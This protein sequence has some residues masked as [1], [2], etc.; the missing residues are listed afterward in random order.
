[1]LADV[2]ANERVDCDGTW[3]A[4]LDSMDTDWLA[5]TNART[6]PSA[7]PVVPTFDGTL[8]AGSACTDTDSDGMPDAWEDLYTNVDK[9]SSDANN[10]SDGDGWLAIEEYLMKCASGNSCSPDTNTQFDGTEP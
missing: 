10:D 7:T 6:A 4:T 9:T 3:V 5:K 2:G 1:M 8:T